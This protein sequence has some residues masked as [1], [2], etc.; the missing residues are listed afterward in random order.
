MVNFLVNTQQILPI[1]V[2]SFK[3]LVQVD[4]LIKENQDELLE[5]AAFC[6]LLLKHYIALHLHIKEHYICILQMQVLLQY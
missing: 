2:K 5:F 4:S 1:Q 3:W 6:V